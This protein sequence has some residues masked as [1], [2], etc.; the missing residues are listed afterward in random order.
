MK[1]LTYCKN[2][3]IFNIKSLLV[4][5]ILFSLFLSPLRTLRA[6]SNETL[7]I[8]FFG[9]ETCMYCNQEKEYLESLIQD[10]VNIEIHYF[11]IANTS[12]NEYQIFQHVKYTMFNDQ[13]S[14]IPFTI[15]GNNTYVGFNETIKK[16]MTRAIDF[17]LANSYHD[18]VGAYLGLNDGDFSGMENHYFDDS[19]NTIT[20][21]IFG[22][23]DVTAISLP[24]LSILIGTIDGFNPC[25]MWVLLFII[26][27]LFNLKD[28]KR[29]WILGITFLTASALVYLMFMLAWL[30]VVLFL[31]TLWWFRL[32]IS[33]IA[34]LGGSYNLYSY[35]KRRKEEG[36]KIIDTKKRKKMS[37]RLI[38]ITEQQSL[39]L[40][41]LGMVLLA[42]SVNIVELACSAGL[43]VIYTSILAYN[44]LTVS[45]Y[46]I[47][48]GLYIF[49]F[50]LDDL[51]VFT[52]SMKTLQ[53]TGFSTKY[54]KIASLVGGIIMVLLGFLLFF[55]PEWIMLNF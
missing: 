35:Y 38:R 51:I 40:A 55:K 32:L 8:Y 39:L 26:T 4:L 17:Y 28:R 7:P 11:N 44:D 41:M 14:G 10:G 20:L 21:P 29:M 6:Q 34:I 31:G 50:L 36:C 13:P 16:Q 18:I 54:G 30:E 15:V 1:Y 9:T 37:K 22:E 25:A 43:P 33:S 42:F 49:F 24:L 3:K 46:A 52:I 23:I 5:V 2:I 47:N 53:I 48:I 19:T 12:S 45:L 27:M